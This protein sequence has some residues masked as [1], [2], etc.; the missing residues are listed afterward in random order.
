MT[1]LTLTKPAARQKIEMHSRVVLDK[2][3]FGPGS[4][5]PTWESKYACKGTVVFVNRD[6]Y[7]PMLPVR[8]EWD[9][10]YANGYKHNHL[11]QIEDDKD[12]PNLSFKLNRRREEEKQEKE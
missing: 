2:C 9:N 10:G 7:S 3:E 12:N 11:I 8:V 1:Q 6:K 5:N 4:N